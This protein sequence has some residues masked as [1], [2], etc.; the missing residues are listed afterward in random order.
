MLMNYEEVRISLAHDDLA[1]AQRM[2]AQMA[3]EFG[4]WPPVSSSV[5]LISNSDS[6]ESARKAFVKLSEE[7]IRLAVRYTEYLILRCPTVAICDCGLFLAVHRMRA[8]LERS[9]P[10]KFWESM[11]GGNI[12]DT[13]SI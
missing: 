13:F 4:D 9:D 6:L 3:R 10:T 5:Q 2:S 11:G 8:T 12:P 7:A 1:T